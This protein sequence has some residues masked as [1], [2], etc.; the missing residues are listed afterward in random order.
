MESVVKALECSD[1]LQCEKNLS[2]LNVKNSELAVETAL[3]GL[4][5]LTGISENLDE[6]EEL[7]DG[8]SGI[9]HLLSLI[10]SFGLLWPVRRIY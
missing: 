3:L 6:Y 10:I 7:L 2:L 8:I 4:R 9:S 5:E 1:F